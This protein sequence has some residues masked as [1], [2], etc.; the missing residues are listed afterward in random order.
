MCSEPKIDN[1]PLSPLTD[2]QTTT[3]PDE[4]N[5]LFS[6]AKVRNGRKVQHRLDKGS[7]VLVE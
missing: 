1:C 2:S 6:H 5:L 4:D 7:Q 3:M